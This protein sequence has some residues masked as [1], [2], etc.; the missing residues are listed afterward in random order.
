MTTFVLVPGFWLGG[1]AWPVEYT[2]GVTNPLYVFVHRGGN[3]YTTAREL[4]ATMTVQVTLSISKGPQTAFVPDVRGFG[5]A[6]A[7][8]TI[9]A[10]GFKAVVQRQDTSDQT[11]DGVVITESAQP[12]KK[13]N[14]PPRALKPSR[15]GFSS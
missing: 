10:A 8:A 6:N 9:R 1:W 12:W 5:V 4:L 3:P 7:V 11:Q 14:L 2:L 15:F 13:M